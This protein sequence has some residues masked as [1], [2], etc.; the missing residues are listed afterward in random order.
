MASVRNNGTAYT[1]VSWWGGADQNVTAC[2]QDIKALSGNGAQVNN[3]VVGKNTAGKSYLQ[4]QSTNT[5]TYSVIVDVQ[6]WQNGAGCSQVAPPLARRVSPL[7]VQHAPA[8]FGLDGSKL[9]ASPSRG[10]YYER[11]ADGSVF[12]RVQLK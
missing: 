5:N 6:N 4:I 8:F 12:R 3:F 9:T 10:V 7:V 2:K 1:Q 11:T